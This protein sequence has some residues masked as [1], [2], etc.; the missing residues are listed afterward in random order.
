MASEMKIYPMFSLSC[1]Y[2]SATHFRI[3]ICKYSLNTR[4]YRRTTCTQ[5]LNVSQHAL[6]AYTT[7]QANAHLSAVQTDATLARLHS[8]SA[9]FL[10]FFFCSS[11]T[12]VLWLWYFWY[13]LPII[14]FI[15][16]P[17]FLSAVFYHTYYHFLE[18][19][20]EGK[21]NSSRVRGSVANTTNQHY[22]VCMGRPRL[23]GYKLACG[24]RPTVHCIS[25]MPSM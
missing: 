12:S 6:S 24:R 22:L 4:M 8:A 11:A 5:G 14:H 16:S 13:L 17:P 18:G 19:V 3:S 25:Q 15:T 20:R 10:F 2:F 23:S 21:K 7:T 9:D 1:S